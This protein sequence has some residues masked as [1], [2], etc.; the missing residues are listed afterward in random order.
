MSSNLALIYKIGDF[1][2]WS[3]PLFERIKK[4]FRHSMCTII[5]ADFHNLVHDIYETN[6]TKNPRDLARCIATLET[7]KLFY[8]L[9]EKSKK[10]SKKQYAYCII[11]LTQIEKM[12]YGWKRHI[13]LK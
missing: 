5:T 8:Y 11:Q 12:F 4:P 13:E 6:I 2:L 7:I 10:L 9:C 3:I 1:F